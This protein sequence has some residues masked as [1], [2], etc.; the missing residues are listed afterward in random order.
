[1]KRKRINRKKFL[2]ITKRIERL[3]QSPSEQSESTFTKVS[4]YI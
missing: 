2:G 1:M 4:R 3:Q